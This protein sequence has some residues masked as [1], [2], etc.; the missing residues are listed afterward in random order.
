MVGIYIQNVFVN[1]TSSSPA[2]LSGFW[3]G[4]GFH[5]YVDANLRHVKF[6]FQ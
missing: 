6:P 4:V 3:T 5:P 1:V 2:Q